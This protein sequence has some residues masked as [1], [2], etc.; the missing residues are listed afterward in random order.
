MQGDS[1]LNGLDGFE[2][3]KGFKGDRGDPYPIQFPIIGLP[4]F[5]GPDGVSNF[6]P[7]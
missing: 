7:S 5:N 3:L 6:Y 2:G 1:G 4:G